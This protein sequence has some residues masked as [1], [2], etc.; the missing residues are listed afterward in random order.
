V[1]LVLNYI[2]F[3]LKIDQVG[4]GRPLVKFEV[5]M[6]GWFPSREPTMKR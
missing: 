6:H 5:F 2:P 3:S 1:F 4:L